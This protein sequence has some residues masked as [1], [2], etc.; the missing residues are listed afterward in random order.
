MG[1]TSRN[2]VALLA[3]AVAV[4]AAAIGFR[5]YQLQ[6]LH[7]D[8]LKAQARRQHEQ[9]IEIEGKRGNIVDRF[10]RELAV[11]LETFSL[12]AHPW[13]VQ[14]PARVAR[15][16]A[17][18]LGVAE[19]RLRD[20]LRSEAPFVWLGRRLDPAVAAVVRNLGL[21]IGSG[22]PFG[23]EVE[24]KR[25][26]PQGSLAAHAIGFANIDQ[27][28]VEG[29]EHSFDRELQGDSSSYLAVRD[30]RGGN[31]LHLVRPP[32]RQPD[33]VVMTLDLVLQHIVERELDRAMRTTRARSASA[34]VLDPTTGEI[35]ALANR[36]TADLNE[37]GK[38]EPED[39]RNR[40]VV[41]IYEPGS[42]F[43]V[44]TGAVALDRGV[45]APS[46]VFD[47][48]RGSYAIASR[49]IRDHHPYGALTFREILEH[50]S[51]IGMI[52]VA[53]RLS[54]DVLADYIRRFGFGRRTGI[55]LPGEQPGLVAASSRWT[56]ST[57]VSISFGHEVGVT[58]LQMASAIATVANDGV[59]VPPRIVLGT[60]DAHGIIHPAPSGEPRRVISSETARILTGLLEG[61]VLR[62]TGRS[63]RL[64]GYRIAG[65]TGTAHKVIPGVGYSP[66]QFIA[67][68]A[69]FGP[70]RS[71]R[72]LTLVV[73][74]SPAGLIHTGG[75]AAGPVFHRIMTDGLAYLR[76]P[77]DEDLP[78]PSR[79]E[80]VRRKAPRGGTRAIPA[81]PE[82]EEGPAHPVATLPGQVP[83]LFGMN[84][85]EAVTTLAARKYRV[86]ALGAGFVVAQAPSPGTPL[87]EG[88]LCS[89]QLSMEDRA[90]R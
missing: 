60:R 32:E 23:F 83:D 81:A 15:L 61:V 44:V 77:P 4:G 14:D 71:P 74:D 42:T 41:D 56:L 2:R 31:V 46:D 27:K 35:L 73:V 70:I 43:K 90:T 84:L 1:S 39:R 33:D 78:S 76:V 86:A 88:Q 37:Y 63:A 24:G 75:L 10:G 57:H 45:V 66:S 36:P 8:E 34:V 19:S 30:G 89:L 29:I 65:K 52:K 7:A 68:F 69:G 82:K 50:S 59:R 49:R 17:P 18:V 3:L 38:A 58:T 53:H 64:P 20:Q 85:R 40:A 25:F 12:F 67:S 26:Y 54:N 80:I 55:E 79:K 16:L 9:Q 51:N 6:W 47:C 5:L 22:Q 28:G 21:P 48:E 13:K 62:G 11:S 87:L 72:L